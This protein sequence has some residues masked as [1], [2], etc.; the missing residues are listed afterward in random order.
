MPHMK[1]KH[2]RCSEQRHRW[3]IHQSQDQCHCVLR[4]LT[5]QDLQPKLLIA[6][7]HI[8]SKP[9][10]SAAKHPKEERKNAGSNSQIGTPSSSTKLF[11]TKRNKLLRQAQRLF[12][13]LQ[14][15][16]LQEQEKYFCAIIMTD[17]RH[18][19]VNHEQHCAEDS[20]CE[21]EGAKR[22]HIAASLHEH[23][24]TMHCDIA[25]IHETEMCSLISDTALASRNDTF[26]RCLTQLHSDWSSK[27]STEHLDSL[28][29]TIS[30][31]QSAKD[32]VTDADSS[33]DSLALPS[34]KFSDPDS[35]DEPNI[36]PTTIITPGQR[37]ST[38]STM[39]IT[40][41]VHS[42]KASRVLLR[43]NH[44]L[45]RRTDNFIRDIFPY[46]ESWSVV[47]VN[48]S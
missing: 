32:T 13:D 12:T 44:P 34:G 4:Q 31:L 38:D 2:R 41:L 22:V 1:K 29:S 5:P 45:P 14:L 20:L 6:R 7:S 28:A 3:L 15:K 26:R 43:K 18:H 23:L 36:P 33:G 11:T 35:Y 46:V 17:E 19:L 47:A 48:W 21:N 9:S 27:Y 42:K 37:Y 30:D 25:V 40:T 39:K 24:T 10:R 8:V 16:S